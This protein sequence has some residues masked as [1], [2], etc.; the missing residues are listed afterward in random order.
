[1]V[2]FGA[3]MTKIQAVTS[4]KISRVGKILRGDGLKSF[5]TE[6]LQEYARDDIVKKLV[7][8]GSTQPNES[9]NNVIGSK[10]LKV[11]YY[12]GSASSD[13]RTAAAISQFNEG[14]GYL[15]QAS[16]ILKHKTCLGVLGRYV[17]KRNLERARQSRRQRTF[18]FRRSRRNKKKSTEKSGKR[19]EQ[20]EGVT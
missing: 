9:L 16:I 13:H 7:N 15:V 19:K 1:M 17:G 14:H 20:S 12:G 11:R 4:T 3:G 2:E 8:L 6:T 18:Y 5:L 10:N